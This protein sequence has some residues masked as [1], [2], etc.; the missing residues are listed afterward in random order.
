VTPT[1]RQIN[2]AI[3][4]LCKEHAGLAVA[5]LAGLISDPEQDGEVR[6][7]ASN[8]IL[9]RAYGKA[10]D[11]I[12]IAQVGGDQARDARLL[13]TEDI[14]RMLTP[15]ALENDPQ[16]ACQAIISTGCETL[17][18]SYI[19]VGDT[20]Q[21]GSDDPHHGD[22]VAAHL[23]QPGAWPWSDTEEEAASRHQD[24]DRRSEDTP[25]GDLK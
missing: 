25:L 14:I 3:E 5:C 18:S 12:A 8:D 10:V 19:V 4:E 20:E 9:D 16:E 2:R 7:K 21:S 15:K 1:K 13:S 6:R 24:D 23:E 22:T 11:R 17:E